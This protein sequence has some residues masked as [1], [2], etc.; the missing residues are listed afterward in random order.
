MEGGSNINHFMNEEKTALLKDNSEFFKNMK[1]DDKLVFAPCWCKHIRH[2]SGHL[3]QDGSE[4]ILYWHLESFV[5][6]TDI[7]P[8][9]WTHC[10]WCGATRPT[11]IP[12][13]PTQPS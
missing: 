12:A 11:W 2:E 6:D 8:A 3:Y 10:P 9:D 7:C 4:I 1:P 5:G 13:K